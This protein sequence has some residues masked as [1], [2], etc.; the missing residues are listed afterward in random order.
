[1]PSRTASSH[2]IRDYGV[3]RAPGTRQRFSVGGDGK[4]TL[5]PGESLVVDVGEDGAVTIGD[6]R[7]RAGERHRHVDERHSQ[8]P[9]GC[10]TL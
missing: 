6:R 1:M 7:D 4:I 3:R 5:D 8:Q 9:A 10:A 2:D